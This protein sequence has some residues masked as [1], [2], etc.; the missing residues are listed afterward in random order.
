M[1][2][3]RS[4]VLK[5]GV[6]RAPHRALL[7]SM[8]ISGQSMKRPFVAIVNSWNELVPGHI[9]LRRLGEA[10][11]DGVRSAGGTPFEFDTIGVCDGLAMGHH[12][13]KYSL[14]SREVIA[15]SIEIMVKAHCLD[16]MV[17]ISS[18]VF[19]FRHQ[20]NGFKPTHHVKRGTP[21]SART[22]PV[23][24][25]NLTPTFAATFSMYALAS[26][27]WSPGMCSGRS[28][29]GHFIRLIRTR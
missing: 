22:R 16:A 25:Y 19:I 9:H 11:K 15:D 10:A 26:M 8:G 18:S 4:D 14:A 6:D 21:V 2:R 20:I 1:M 17:L 7:R 27:Y 5:E 3:L 13:M 29:R 28:E 24:P 23:H 12:G